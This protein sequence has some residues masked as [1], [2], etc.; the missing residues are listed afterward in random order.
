MSVKGNRKHT[1]LS[2]HTIL[3]NIKQQEEDGRTEPRQR[4]DEHAAPV[5]TVKYPESRPPFKFGLI[6][7]YKRAL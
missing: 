7:K 2:L 3:E 5:R 4:L 1:L 6:Y